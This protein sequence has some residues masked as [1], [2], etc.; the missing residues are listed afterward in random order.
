MR[1]LRIFYV[2]FWKDLSM[3]NFLFTEIL[4][5]HYQVIFDDKNPE[6]IFCSTFGNQYLKYQCPRILFVGEPYTPDFNLYDYAIGFD[7]IQFM[8]RYLRYPLYLLY[9]KQMEKA[10]HKH[11]MTKEEILGKKGFCNFVVSSG[12]GKGDN[13]TKIFEE[14]SQYKRVDSGGKYKNNLPDH[15][16]VPDKYEFQKNYKFSLAMENSKF[17]GYTT[18]K[19]IDAWAAGTIPIY[20]GNPDI[21]KEF[22]PASFIMIE[23]GE[24]WLDRVKEIDQSDDLYVEMCKEPIYLSGQEPDIEALEKFLLAIVNKDRREQ[25]VRGSARSLYGTMYE[26]R[27]QQMARLN[28][29]RF[30]NFLRKQKRRMFGLRKFE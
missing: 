10:L 11:E 2:D 17:S 24:E 25:L 26:Y 5:K 3:E 15:Q 27:M 12:G 9:E 1:E 21:M 4:K 18:E 7:H 23:D 6:I 22:N 16:P 13:R 14:L 19:I 28:D 20:W 30:V 8:D 29:N